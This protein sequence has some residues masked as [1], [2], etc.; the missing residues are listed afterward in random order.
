MA[1]YMV[2][3]GDCLASIA[4][5]FQLPT[6]KIWNDPANAQ[7]RADRDQNV[8]FPGDVLHIPERSE[9]EFSRPT[10]VNHK[11]QVSADKT[12]LVVRLIDAN[13]PR[14]NLK[15]NIAIDGA[16]QRQGTTN[17]AGLLIEPIVGDAQQ[18]I[19]KVNGDAETYSLTLGSL[20]PVSTISG[21]QARLKNLGYGV[22]EVTGTLNPITID[23]IS[24][25]QEKNNLPVSGQNDAA[26][27]SSLKSAYGS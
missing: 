12:K 27:Q 19:L 9:A 2:V 24:V 25:Y 7:L 11:F 23:A 1:D 4:L 14:I 17:G 5:Q 22:I 18:A 13:G 3:Q 16:P 15:Y 6:D 10:D 21:A 20:D 8:L 26:T